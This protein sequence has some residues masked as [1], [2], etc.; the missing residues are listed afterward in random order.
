MTEPID[1]AVDGKLR[2]LMPKFLARRAEEL[3]HMKAALAAGDL[4]QLERIGHTLRGSAGSYGFD[5][6]GEIGKRIEAAAKAHDAAELT[7]L[8]ADAEDHL[9]RAKV[10]FV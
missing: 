9:A 3:A 8:V 10:R 1:I 2:P 4:A 7:R 6:L 5:Q